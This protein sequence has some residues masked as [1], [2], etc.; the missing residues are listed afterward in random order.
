MSEVKLTDFTHEQLQILL[1]GLETYRE[2][3]NQGRVK[4]RDIE[5]FNLLRT[6]LLTAIGFVTRRE[7]INAN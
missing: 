6:Q 2:D 7:Q 5:D 4:M 1:N 3:M